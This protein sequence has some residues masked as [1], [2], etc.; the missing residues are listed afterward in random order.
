MRLFSGLLIG[1]ESLISHGTALNTVADNLANSNTVGF[2]TS[3]AEFSDLLADSIGSLYSPTNQTGSGTQVSSVT[4]MF[5]QGTLELTSR[6]LDFSILGNGFFV[7]DNAG[8]TFFSRAGN[9]VTDP[10][11]NIVTSSG[12]ALMG[13][14]PDGTTLTK[15]SLGQLSSAAQATTEASLKGNLDAASD[16]SPAVGAPATFQEL[17]AASGFSAPFSL[18]DSLGTRQEVAMHFFHDAFLNWTAQA[19]VDAEEVGGVAGTPA[20]LGEAQIAFGP[21]G[22]QAEGAGAVLQLAA[23]WANGAAASAV[24]VDLS[25]FTG[26]SSVSNVSASTRNGQT[27]GSPVGIELQKDGVVNVTLDNG[28]RQTIG[29]LALAMFN[30]PQGLDRVGSNRFQTTESAGE[31]ALGVAKTE[32]R[33][34]VQNGS[35][36]SSTVDAS[37]EFVDL[38]RY[39]RGYQAGSSVISTMDEIINQTI[40]LK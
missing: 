33:G 24:T 21:D 14:G 39:Q 15:L 29:T 11:G 34:E 6:D 30:N 35:L 13:F 4:N 18:I 16:L 2:K 1:R 25:G 26:F 31:T 28:E 36:E 9:F 22:L 12:D 20:L 37:R 3:R 32:G 10:E 23:N 5:E 27:T 19:Y 17:N 40:N 38:I 7:L 8:E